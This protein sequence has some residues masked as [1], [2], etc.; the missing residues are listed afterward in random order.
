MTQKNIVVDIKYCIGCWAC[1]MA[2][3]QENNVPVGIKWINVIKVGPKMVGDRLMMDFIPMRCRH[4]SKAPCIEACPEDAITKRSDG[5]V[6]I[7]R[8]SCIGCLNCAEVCPF[9][10][11]QFNE[12]TGTVEK[13]TLCVH[14]IDT[15]LEPACV[16]AC[17]SKCIHF[18]AI[19]EIMM[20]G[21]AENTEQILESH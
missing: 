17:P 6:L 13:C 18:G 14:R 16:L 5:I 1:E 10:A 15:G 4:C 21:Q 3:K 12:Q 2:C 9:K 11:I 19:N 7:D 20:A 8:E